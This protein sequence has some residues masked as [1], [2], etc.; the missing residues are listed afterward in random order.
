MDP[1]EVIDLCRR[2]SY[3]GIGVPIGAFI[4]RPFGVGDYQAL[5]RSSPARV[6]S[7]VDDI[8]CAPRVGEGLDLLLRFGALE[9]LFPEVA[10]LRDLGDAGGLHKDVWEHTKAVVAGVAPEL[11]LRWGALVHDVGKVATRRIDGRGRVTFHGHDAVGARLVDGMGSRTPVFD[12]RTGLLRSVRALVLNHLRPASYAASWS[13]SGVRRLVHDL[14]GPAGFER[15]MALSRADLTT[16]NPRRRRE[17]GRRAD[18][19]EARVRTVLATDNRPRLPK[20]TMGIVA[21]KVAARP[22]PWLNEVR[23]RLEAMMAAGLLAAD[24]TA[25]DYAVHGLSLVEDLLD[26]AEPVQG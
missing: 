18:E 10:A 14:G 11:D 9:A 12:G 1:I 2:A 8:L 15:L 7:A 21:S 6:R 25:D 13:D 19:L 4:P 5:W 20:G 26:A 3:D 16:K 23:T 22:G 17:A 24:L